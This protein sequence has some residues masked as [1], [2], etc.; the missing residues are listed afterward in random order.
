MYRKYCVFCNYSRVHTN[1]LNR[2][3]C[4]RCKRRYSFKRAERIKKIIEYFALEVP[5]NKAAKVLRLNFKTTYRIYQRLRGKIANKSEAEFRKLSSEIEVDDA[6]FGGK[7]KGKRGRGAAGKVMVLGM[8]ERNGKVF[9][10]AL[11]K[12]KATDILKTIKNKAEKGSVF[13]SDKFKSYKSLVL[14]GRHITLDH[15]KEFANGRAHINGLE[16][17]WSFAKER[18]LK[19]HGISKSNFHLYLKELEFRYNHRNQN[20]MELF[21]K[22]W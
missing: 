16:G 15:A 1:S 19:Y 21:I 18:M 6:Y 7:R 9:T 13:Y 20:L 2:V 8:L 14:L 22:L 17:F 5:A 4:P 12:A 3:Y 11:E 10:T